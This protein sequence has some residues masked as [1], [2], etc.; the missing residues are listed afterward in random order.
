MAGSPI[1]WRAQV[2]LARAA[3]LRDDLA[4]ARQ[5]YT[6]A[7]ERAPRPVPTDL[8]MQMSGDLGGRGH[9]AEL[10]DFTAPYY[11]P[12]TH[13]LPVG[14]NLIKANFDLGRLATAE[15]LKTT[16]ARMNE[17][18]NRPDWAQAIAYWDNE[19]ARRRGGVPAAEPESP[20]L[21]IGLIRVDGP[22][23][24]PVNSPARGI[25]GNK[26]AQ[27]PSV[28][29]L[30]GTAELPPEAID[31]EKRTPEQA[32]L[33]DLLAR[34]TRAL[35]LFFAEQ[36]E[37]LTGAHGR[38]MVPW[39]TGPASGFVVSGS[40]WSDT[41]AVQMLADPA[42]AADY[43]VT[44]HLDAEVEP[45]TAMLAFVR[46]ADGSRIGELEAEFTPADPE[47]GLRQ[48]ASEVVELL[49]A[50]AGQ[51]GSQATYAVPSGAQ[52]PDYL[53]RLEQ[54]LAVRCAGMEGVPPSFLLGEQEIVAGELAL[55]HAAPENIAARLVLLETL[56]VLER[57]R[58][59]IGAA[60]REPLETLMTEN[61]LPAL[62]V[63]F[64]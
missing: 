38:A 12:E 49:G 39:A 22:I 25:F 53:L 51:V 35:P 54:L 13:G 5:W 8:L 56:T 29:F 48:L 44:V 47:T 62:N 6:N 34:M 2:W 18:L 32:I 21:Q 26:P 43:V 64:A 20:G 16:L 46:T 40:A 58:P 60:F 17:Q 4:A 57:T 14:N 50:A 31:P 1:S 19:I 3:L 61:P 45:W 36:T 15:R 55:C 24:L 41:I 33:A 10:I 52:F 63:S 27:G 30:G 42:N 11:L 23:W 37:M 9:L 59:G 7:L 28:T